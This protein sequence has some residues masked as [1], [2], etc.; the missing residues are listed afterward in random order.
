MSDAEVKE[1]EAPKKKGGA[2]GLIIG[3]VGALALGGGA[4]F[5][6]ST[7]MVDIPGLTDTGAA[8]DKEEKKEEKPE[9]KSVF[10]ELSDISVPVVEAR[11]LRQ[12]QLRLTIETTVAH[13]ADVGEMTPR[14]L[15]TLNTMLR[16]TVRDDLSDPT[17]LDRL[18]AQMLR[19]VRI[20]TGPEAVK[21]LLIVNYLYL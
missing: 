12:L 9:E 13:E 4:A 2:L 6:I 8:D 1:E 7:G 5:T 10:I 16:T 3:L 18:R 17:A 21:D 14:I 11:Q 20:V 15:D 19:R